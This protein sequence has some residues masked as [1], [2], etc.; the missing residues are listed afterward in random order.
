M[1]NKLSW[2]KKGLLTGALIGA[3][4]GGIALYWYNTQLADDKDY[5]VYEFNDSERDISDICPSDQRIQLTLY[6]VRSPFQ[7]DL[8]AAWFHPE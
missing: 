3:G 4:A 2:L 7:G 8:Q 1:N 6:I 5:Y